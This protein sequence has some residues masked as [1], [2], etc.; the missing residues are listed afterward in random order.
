MKVVQS[1][2]NQP[3]W[4]WLNSR[5]RPE[6]LPPVLH[7]AMSVFMVQDKSLETE[8]GAL[9]IVL[10]EVNTDIATIVAERTKP[11]PTLFFS[12]VSNA[13]ESFPGEF[14]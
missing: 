12:V 14:E 3:V 10:L 13:M 9:E 5:S 2:F 11:T 1:T 8:S 6:L 7:P 4:D